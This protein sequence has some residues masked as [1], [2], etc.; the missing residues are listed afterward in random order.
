MW[1]KPSTNSPKRPDRRTGPHRCTAPSIPQ[2]NSARAG[3]LAVIS[4]MTGATYVHL[5]VDDPDLF[6]LQPKRPI[7][8]LGVIGLAL[9]VVAKHRRSLPRR[10]DNE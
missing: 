7:V 6:P 2:R 3:A 10:N 8:P 4:M 1:R 5:V 9:S